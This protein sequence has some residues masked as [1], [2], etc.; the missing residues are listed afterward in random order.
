MFVLIVLQRQDMDSLKRSLLS[1]ESII[2]SEIDNV[3][4]TSVSNSIS[5]SIFI[6]RF[7]VSITL[8]TV[9]HFNLL[10]GDYS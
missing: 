1:L 6:K 9:R 7:P 10:F 4:L 2:C 5:F 8:H 3:T